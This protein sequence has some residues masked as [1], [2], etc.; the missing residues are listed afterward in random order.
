MSCSDISLSRST[1]LNFGLNPIKVSTVVSSD[2]DTDTVR[3]NNHTEFLTLLSFNLE[4]GITSKYEPSGFRNSTRMINVASWQKLMSLP[5]SYQL[6]FRP[7][8]HFTSA[9]INPGLSITCILRKPHLTDSSS[10]DSEKLTRDKNWAV[11]F[12]YI[13][14]DYS[15]L[16]ST[17][18]YL[19]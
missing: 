14:W 10:Q 1:C 5:Y 11:K 12:G 16:Y 8:K 15:Y 9:G 17:V 6:I 18:T 13:W 2:I 7:W 19:D 3:L 4:P